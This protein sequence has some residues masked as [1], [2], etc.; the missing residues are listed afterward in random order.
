MLQAEH[1]HLTLCACGSNLL[2]VD[3]V[4]NLSAM[5][6]TAAKRKV[7]SRLLLSKRQDAT[8]TGCSPV[9][10]HTLPVGLHQW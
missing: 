2:L 8:T 6:C 7:N 4:G 9:L 1:L 5:W 10:P 3:E